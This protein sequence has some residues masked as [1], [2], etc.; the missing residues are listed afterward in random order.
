MRGAEA[1]ASAA[2][3]IAKSAAKATVVAVAARRTRAPVATIPA[4]SPL[5]VAIVLLAHLDR[6]LLVQLIDAHRQ[7]AEDVRRNPHLA[8]HF[9]H[10]LVRRLDVEERVMRAPVLLDLVGCGLE[11]PIFGLAD[12]SAIFLNDGLVGVHQP[13]HLLRRHILA[14]KKGML[15]RVA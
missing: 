5:T 10:R 1:A 9:E 8:L 11:T 13:C 2:F 6:R 4:V 15:V 3:T 14:R 7:E 12:L